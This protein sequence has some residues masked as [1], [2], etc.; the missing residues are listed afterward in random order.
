MIR[1]K[2]AKY[3]KTLIQENRS[4]PKGVWKAIQKCLPDNKS[5][6]QRSGSFNITS[7]V[8]KDK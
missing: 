4:N 1:R 6:Q 3:H 2:E 8:T 7:I 5:C